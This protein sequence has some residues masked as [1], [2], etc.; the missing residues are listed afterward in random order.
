MYIVC[1][2]DNN[3]GKKLKSKRE[4]TRQVPVCREINCTKKKFEKFEQG[5]RTKK[6]EHVR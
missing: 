2:T 1:C 6:Q 4:K 5:K 3:G